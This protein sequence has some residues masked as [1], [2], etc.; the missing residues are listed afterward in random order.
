[1]RTG[2]RSRTGRQ[3]ARQIAH[4]RDLAAELP[5]L[6]DAAVHDRAAEIER[7]GRDLIGLLE[8]GDSAFGPTALDALETLAAA[9]ATRRDRNDGPGGN[10][11]VYAARRLAAILFAF[12]DRL[13]EGLAR[14]LGVALD[15]RPRH[16]QL[17]GALETARRSSGRPIVVRIST[18]HALSRIPWWR[19]LWIVQLDPGCPPRPVGDSS[20]EQ[21]DLNWEHAHVLQECSERYLLRHGESL[22]VVLL[23]ED[24]LGVYHTAERVFGPFD[25]TEAMA[26]VAGCRWEPDGEV[27]PPV[28]DQA[29]AVLPYRLSAVIDRRR[30][31]AARADG[32]S[33]GLE[34]TT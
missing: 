30:A 28:S 21:D 8:T 17:C 33:R 10:P 13:A 16:H 11:A 3:A 23:V 15:D 27:P 18:G 31:S 20:S 12:R 32:Q 24:E 14:E 25:A 22:H 6:S 5:R 9:I 1:M 2:R 34:G 19:T 4:G 7:A 26:W 29:A